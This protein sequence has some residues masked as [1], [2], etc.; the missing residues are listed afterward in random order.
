MN[1]FWIFGWLLSKCSSSFVFRSPFSFILFTIRRWTH[2]YLM[3]NPQSITNHDIRLSTS[4]V[5]TYFHW[6][7]SLNRTNWLYCSLFYLFIRHSYIIQLI[8][9]SFSGRLIHFLKLSVYLCYFWLFA[10]M[11][12]VPFRL[13]KDRYSGWKFNF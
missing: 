7:L 9:L 3:S 4:T 8:V 12:I 1:S 6:Q 13:I 10:Q 5:Q 11:S 2:F